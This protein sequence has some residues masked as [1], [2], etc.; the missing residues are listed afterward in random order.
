MINVAAE[1]ALVSKLKSL[2][3]DVSGV[4]DG[5]MTSEQRQP[6]VWAALEPFRD[7]TMTVR[8]G[9]RV[10]L[11]MQYADAYGNVP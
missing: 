4:F 5:L 2:G 8:N 3:A 9:K 7:V 10:T 6:K 11:E 1:I